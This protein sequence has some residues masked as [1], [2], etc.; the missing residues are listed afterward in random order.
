MTS[1]TMAAKTDT[2]L[3]RE[4]LD[5]LRWEASVNAA[6]IGVSVKGA[7]VTLTGHVPSYAEKWGAERAA[8]RVEGVRAVANELDVHLPS[9]NVRTDQDIAGACVNALKQ[10]ILVPDQRIKATVRKGWVELEGEV[11]WQFQRDAAE[12]AVRYLPGVMGVSNLITVRPRV[13]ASD[14]K[15]KIENAFKR[16]AAMDANRISVEV[17]GGKVTLRGTVRSWAERDEAARTAWSAPGIIDVDNR[18]TVEP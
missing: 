2:D 17:S 9:D 3:Q 13:T 15:S 8:K 5:E 7:V 6:D 11:E 14:L 12:R 18:I 10:N 16:S 1:M 4:V